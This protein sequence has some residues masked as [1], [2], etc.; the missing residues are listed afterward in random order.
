M[1]IGEASAAVVEVDTTTPSVVAADI[2]AMAPLTA[3]AVRVA[4]ATT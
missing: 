1:V 2:K 3:A 4:P